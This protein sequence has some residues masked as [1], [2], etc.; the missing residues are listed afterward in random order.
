MGFLGMGWTRGKWRQ[1]K[2]VLKFC[3]GRVFRDKLE[4]LVRDG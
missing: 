1:Y 4:F 3:E 2:R